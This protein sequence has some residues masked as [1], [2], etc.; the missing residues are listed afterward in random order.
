M[1]NARAVVGV[2]KHISY[3]RARCGNERVHGASALP[4]RPGGSDARGSCG[5]ASPLERQVLEAPRLRPGE[6]RRLEEDRRL[7]AARGYPRGLCAVVR[8]HLQAD[9]QRLSIYDHARSLT[10][11]F[12]YLLR[13]PRVTQT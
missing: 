12:I 8:T 13:N 2:R 5:D 6:V 10:T 11:M 3:Q 7:R 9:E 4:S 1:Y